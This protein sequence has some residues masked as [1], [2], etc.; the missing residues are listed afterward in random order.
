MSNIAILPARLG[1]KRIKEKNIKKF[2]GKPIIQWTYEILKKSNIFSHIIVSTESEKIV[3]VCKKFGINTFIKR[4]TKLSGD[5]IGIREVMQHAIDQTQKK[6]KFE[7]VCC[8]FPCSP[9]L[10]IKN[11]KE[12]LKYVKNN[13]NY[14]VHPVSKFRCPPEKSLT[15]QKGK[16][17]KVVNTKNMKKM[18]QSFVSKY[19]DVGQF[20]FTHKSYWFKEKKKVKGIGIELQ[21]WDTVDIDNIE[22]W[23]FAKILFKLRKKIKLK[24]KS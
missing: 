3:Q 8:V 16:Q 5:S 22:D 9:F 14:L 20:Y 10:K 2:Y 13:K 21:V 18:T 7:N 12:A 17:L 23:E 24:S 1:S 6:I 15:M 11:L 4:P 19:H